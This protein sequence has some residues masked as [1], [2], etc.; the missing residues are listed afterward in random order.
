MTIVLRR[1]LLDDIAGHSL[2]E[3]PKEACGIMVGELM[4]KTKVVKH[5]FKTRNRLSSSSRYEIDPEDQL[6]VFQEAERLKLE[7]IGFYHSHPYWEPLP[8]QVDRSLAFYRGYSYSI[9]S[10]FT[11][12]LGSYVWNGEKFEEEQV[13]II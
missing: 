5:V 11:R 1:T 8:S 3:Y 7:V 10:V 4:G 9:Y 12:T 13:K 2:N 6:K